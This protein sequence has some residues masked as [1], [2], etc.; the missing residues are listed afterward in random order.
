M[1]AGS[2]WGWTVARLYYCLA[3]LQAFFM[4]TRLNANDAVSIAAG[5]TV[6]LVEVGGSVSGEKTS[7]LVISIAVFAMV[8]PLL[9]IAYTFARNKKR[10]FIYKGDSYREEVLDELVLPKLYID[11]GYEHRRFLGSSQVEHYVESEKVNIFLFK[12]SLGHKKPIR[13]VRAE[14]SYQVPCELRPM[15]FSMLSRLFARHKEQRLF[16]GKL[17]RMT[18]DILPYEKDFRPIAVQMSRYFDGQVT[19]EMVFRQIVRVDSIQEC[20]EGKT[21]LV[22]E[23]NTLIELWKSRC[24]NFIG[25]STIAITKD[26]YL[27]IGRQGPSSMANRSRYAPSGSGSVD[28]LDYKSVASSFSECTLQKVV[29]YAAEREL[30]E[31]CSIKSLF[32]ME[33]AVIGFARLLERGGKPDFFCLTFIDATVAQMEEEFVGSTTL[34]EIGLSESVRAIRI[35]GDRSISDVLESAMHLIRNEGGGISIQLQLCASQLRAIESLPLGKK[36]ID[37]HRTW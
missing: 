17:L 15:V 35:E 18:G 27:L 29:V 8:V 22:D 23:D 25:A 14:G 10:F 20:F 11:N 28:Y 21:L 33:T 9:R 30:R 1:R 19:N 3:R 2:F 16:N 31:E 12:G 6:F 34:K 4:A 5:T 7:S 36:W 24:A 26:G 13:L 32:H 37:Q